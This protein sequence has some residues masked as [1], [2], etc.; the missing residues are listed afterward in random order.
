MYAPR[1]FLSTNLVSFLQKIYLPSEEGFEKI[2]RLDFSAI[3]RVT[4]LRCAV[5]FNLNSLKRRV[6]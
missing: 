2:C 6:T 1:V 3:L 4:N 5:Y